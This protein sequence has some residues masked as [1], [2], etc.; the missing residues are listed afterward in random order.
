MRSA[1][2]IR[3]SGRAGTAVSMPERERLIARIRQ[4]RRISVEADDPV[5]SST[6]D[7]SQ[8]ELRA[9]DARLGHLEQLVEGLQD[10]AHRESLRL[11]K[12]IGEL[13]AQIEPA[14]L[15]KALSDDARKR[16]L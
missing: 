5:R 10:S 3:R 2:R 4:I 6:G 12:R 13:E 7:H 1:G 16:G 8:D 11:S 14:T 9:L 15:G